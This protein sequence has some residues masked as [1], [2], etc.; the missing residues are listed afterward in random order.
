[1]AGMRARGLLAMAVVAVVVAGASPALSSDD[2]Y[3]PQ[4]WNLARVRA[5][6]AW[7]YSTGAGVSIGIVDTGVEVD[8][9]DLRSKIDAAA[10]CLGG[11]CREGGAADGHGHGTLVAGIAAAATG[12]GRGVAGV[13]PDARL[14]VAKAV[15]ENGRGSVEDINAGIRWVV[16]HGAKVVN[17]SLGDPN[18]LFVSLLGTPLRPGIEYAWNKGAVPVLASG[19]ENVGL[20]DLGS[21][22]YGGL[23]AVVVGATDRSGRVAG[24]SSSIGN[25]KWGV[26]APGGS[27]GG[28]GEDILSTYT[29]GRYAWVAGTSM[30]APHVS[31]A[32]AL[33][34]A[35]GLDRATAIERLLSSLDRS[36]ACGAGCRGSLDILAAVRQAGA[37]PRTVAPASAASPATTVTPPVSTTTTTEAPVVTTTTINTPT[38]AARAASYRRALAAGTADA[39]AEA[40]KPVIVGAAVA[41]VV[42]SASVLAGV[43]WQRR[44]L[45]AGAGW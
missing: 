1:M 29:N 26:V 43:A 11:T 4:Q 5:P 28:P 44:R 20:L 3:F 45:R 10:N 22:N 41:L 31:G 30:A 21:S 25:A 13:A 6:E 18:F 38:E 12:N 27:G 34:L 19:N 36:V 42:L 23:N 40:G 8:H 33:L 37:S 24:Y 35:Q 39:G 2:T 9:P 16:D 17:L 7:E 32:L 15:D 14:V